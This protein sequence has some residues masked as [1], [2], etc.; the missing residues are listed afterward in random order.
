MNLGALQPLSPYGAITCSSC[1][2][3]G[4]LSTTEWS[5]SNSCSW[6]TD[7]D[8]S[9]PLTE[10]RAVTWGV[11]KTCLMCSTFVSRQVYLTKLPSGTA[12]QRTNDI[13]VFG[14][15]FFRPPTP[16]DIRCCRQSKNVCGMWKTRGSGL[17]VV[18]QPHQAPVN[19][20]SNHILCWHNR[21]VC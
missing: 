11:S 5:S 19:I 8:T 12:L 7:K 15:R 1:E 17:P 9:L 13:D 14:S 6:S 3:L 10:S 21:L 2:M 20:V 4:Q 16:T 18:P